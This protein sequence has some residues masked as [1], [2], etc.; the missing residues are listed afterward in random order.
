MKT[1]AH[2]F[3]GAKK[4]RECLFSVL[5]DACID[6]DLTLTEAVE[7][8]KDIFALNATMFYKINVDANAFSSKYTVSVNPVKI[9]SRALENSNS[10]V[11]VIW[12]DTSGQHRCRVS[13]FVFKFGFSMVLS[14]SLVLPL[15]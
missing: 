7:A 10:L 12:V 2:A 13:C 4:A 11:R 8:A 1:I 15:S 9:D 5:R 14:C 3:S 6:G